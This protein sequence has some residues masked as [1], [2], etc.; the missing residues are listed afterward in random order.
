MMAPRTH[1][2][3]LT[4]GDRAPCGWLGLVAIMTLMS[5]L[6]ERIKKVMRTAPAPMGF[7]VAAAREAEPTMLTVVRLSSGDVGK[8]G[9][10]VSKGA[11]VVIVE[12]SDA[13]KLKRES[14]KAAGSVVGASLEKAARSD[15]ASLKEAGAAFV[16]LD[17]DAAKAEALLEKNV[18]F[19]LSVGLEAED[20][21]LRLIGDLSLEALIVPQVAA[22][23]TVRELLRLRRIAALARTPLLIEVD[24][25]IDASS[26]Q[27]LRESGVAGVIVGGS[28]IG[29]LGKLRETIGSLPPRGRRR[30]EKAEATIPAGVGAGDED[31]WDEDDDL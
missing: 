27:A 21:D 14:D 9:D 7:A 28:S 23:F 31:D 4:S 19:V 1:N 18:G 24:A 15:V 6:E 11:D 25:G 22:G 17:A 8:I 10:A 30:E 26:L 2:R 29:K 13:G 20:T 16:A 3:R 5:K 12:T